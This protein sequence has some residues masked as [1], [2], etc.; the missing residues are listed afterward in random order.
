MPYLL[1]FLFVFICVSSIF[2][3]SL[4]RLALCLVSTMVVIAGGIGLL[5]A[6]FH[7]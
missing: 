2:Y 6:I 7:G 4:R 1:F 5:I 3:P